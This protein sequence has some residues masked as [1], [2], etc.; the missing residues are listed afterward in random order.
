MPPGLIVICGII[1][2]L[3]LLLSLRATLQLTAG[4]EFIVTF[5][6]AFLK[7]RVYPKKKNTP[8]SVL[9]EQKR[10]KKKGQQTA[11]GEPH[12]IP[13]KTVNRLLHLLKLAAKFLKTML[14]RYP[15]YF[16]LKLSRV[17]VVVG[18]DD[19]AQAAIRY[20]AVS[21]AVAYLVTYIEQFVKVKTTR[22][23]ELYVQPD[24]TSDRLDYDIDI[25]LSISARLLLA[26]IFKSAS[27]HAKVKRNKHSNKQ[28][29]N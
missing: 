17:I 18:G 11:A 16:R 5:K 12:P 2:L 27:S 21:S 26:L 15:N 7:F 28:K 8:K 25:S 10:A 9:R 14:I 6:I 22:K 29:E 24:F 4:D 3:V 20:G 19:A 13:K 23:S 1:L